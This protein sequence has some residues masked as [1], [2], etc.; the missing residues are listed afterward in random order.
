MSSH[1]NASHNLESRPD[2]DYFRY[3]PLGG[4]DEVGMNCAIVEC[5]GSMLMVDCGYTFPEGDAYGVDYVLP[6]WSYVTDNLDRLDGVL[7]THGHQDHIGALPY[8]LREVDVPVYSGDLTLTMIEDQL[9][10]NDLAD[11]VDLYPIDTSEILEIGP[12]WVEFVH[13]NHSVPNARSISLETP[14]GRFVITGDWKLDQTAMYEPV[15]DLQTFAEFGRDGTVAVFGDST[16]AQ[17]D[18]FST[19]EHEV[20]QNVKSVA[21]DA[22][23]RVIVAQF[24]SNV[25]RLH[26]MVELAAEQNRKVLLLGRSIRDN[27]QLARESGHLELSDP[28]IM[29]KPHELGQLPD[30]RILILSTGS[31]AEPRASL[32]R[33]SHGDHHHVT[34]RDTDTV[35]ISARAIPGNKR[36]IQSMIDDLTRRGANVVEAADAPIH[37]SGH[38]CAEELKLMANLTDPEYLV[39]VHGHYRMRKEHAKLG[40]QVGVPEQELIENGD[41]LQFTRDDTRV[42]GEVETGRVIVDGAHVWDLEEIELR[43]RAKLAESGLV[44]A[45]AVVDRSTGELTAPPELVQRGFLDDEPDLLDEAVKSIQHAIEALSNEARRD[46]SEVEG[47]VRRSI[48]QFFRERIERQPVVIPVVHEV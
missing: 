3:I 5:N 10:Q 43:N 27:F 12:F 7:I 31:Q 48:R 2:D 15:M 40:E 42:V 25:H 11:E 47:A 16:N 20:Y 8:F 28:D 36:G 6:D 33:M 21:K 37:G 23:G 17:V 45:H 13:V 30:E 19:S 9:A 14:V 24:S 4:L 22:P 46:V 18:G 34:L 38:A 32:S 44:V 1:D 35:V 26:S 29:I 39:P 41:V